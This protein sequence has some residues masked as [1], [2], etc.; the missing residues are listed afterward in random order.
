MPNSESS[1]KIPIS[2]EVENSSSFNFSFPTPEGCKEISC[3]K[4]ER[5]ARGRSQVANGSEQQAALNWEVT[6]LTKILNDKEVE[7]ASLRSK[8]QKAISRGPGTS[9]GNDQV[10]QKLR[11]ENERLL[12]TNALPSEEVKALNRHLIKG[13][14]PLQSMNTRPAVKVLYN[15]KSCLR[16]K[17]GEAAEYF[18]NHKQGG[19]LYVWY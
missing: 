19:C 18:T 11:D 6:V 2:Q 13:P 4:G 7:I 15:C 8:L 9:D 16:Q 12:K 17:V 5:Q 1:S 3:E 14:G 10:W